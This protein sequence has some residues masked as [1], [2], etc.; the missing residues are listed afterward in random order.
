MLLCVV[1][2]TA[3]YKSE[4][5]ILLAEKYRGEIVSCDSVSVFKGM[6]IG[7]A[8]PNESE[9][10]R[11]PHH[12][13]DVADPLDRTFTVASYQELADKA[14]ADCFSR[15]ILPVI[16]GGSGMYFDSIMHEMKYACPSSTAIR[17][18]LNTQYDSDRI[19]FVSNLSAV[20]PEAASRIPIADK[21]RLVRAMEVYTLTGKPFTSFNQE[22][23][24]AQ[25]IFRYDSI[26]IGLDLPRES[27]YKRIDQRVDIM[28]QDGLLDEV[29]FLRSAGLDISYPSM[30]SIGYK[31][32]LLYL[33]GA[34][35]L[36]NAV[37]EIKKATRH[38]AKRQLTWFKR[39]KGISWFDCSDYTHSIEKIFNY[40]DKR[41]YGE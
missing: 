14:I 27:L 29:R 8:K 10:K 35:S 28:M 41:L 5:A 6:D 4:T 3:C 7:S 21:K 31:Q 32:L 18:K 40:I 17:E 39:D 22:Y 30:Q 9:R 38:L 36:E 19:T 20:D 33:D 24:N 13:I 23:I 25:N 26:R 2:P 37:E 16:C 12:L 11:V 15:N 34:C 1:G